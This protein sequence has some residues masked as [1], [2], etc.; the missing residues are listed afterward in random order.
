MSSYIQLP[1]GFVKKS[2]PIQ[3]NL[4]KNYAES[5]YLNRLPYLSNKDPTV[6]NQVLAVKNRKDLQKWLLAMSDLGQEIQEDV[7]AIVGYNENFN[8][9]VVRRALDFSKSESSDSCFSRY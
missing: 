9:A 5:Q 6:D 4:P 2:E 7:N 8:N 1:Y 3:L